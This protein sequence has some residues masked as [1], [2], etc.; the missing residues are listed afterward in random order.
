MA[1][2]IAAPRP[3]PRPTRID[4]WPPFVR[5]AIWLTLVAGFG[6][7]GALFALNLRPR[8]ATPGS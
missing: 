4:V 6:L 3:A 5:A 2:P 7:G 8:P 1:E